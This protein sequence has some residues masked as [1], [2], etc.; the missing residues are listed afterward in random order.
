MEAYPPSHVIVGL[1]HYSHCVGAGQDSTSSL[2]V[3]E[4]NHETLVVLW[5]RIITNYYFYRLLQLTW[6]KVTL[7][8][9]ELQL[10]NKEMS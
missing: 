5:L 3:D 1:D 2:C 8:E 4:P 7:K 6:K 10:M 9:M